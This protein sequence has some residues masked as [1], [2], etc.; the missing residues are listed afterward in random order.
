MSKAV[1]VLS[2]VV[3]KSA[4]VVSRCPRS[5]VLVSGDGN[6]GFVYM[7]IVSNTRPSFE[8]NTLPACVQVPFGSNTFSLLTVPPWSVLLGWWDC[9]RIRFL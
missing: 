3:E 1:P 5:P 2:A 8:S 9:C 7:S 6:A 4:S